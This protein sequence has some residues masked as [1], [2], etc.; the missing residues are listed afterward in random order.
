M[1]RH[2]H[3]AARE[4]LYQKLLPDT[5]REDDEIRHAILKAM[6]VRHPAEHDKGVIALQMWACVLACKF[7]MKKSGKKFEGGIHEAAVAEVAAGFDM[8][9]EAFKQFVRRHKGPS[10]PF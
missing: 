5:P 1:V 10:W 2:R 8:K 7:H 3:D 9:P 4:A 6:G